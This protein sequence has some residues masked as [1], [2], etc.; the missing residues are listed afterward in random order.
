MSETV[1]SFIPTSSFDISHNEGCKAN[2]EFKNGKPINPPWLTVYD[3][4]W[5]NLKWIESNF[6]LSDTV[7]WRVVPQKDRP[8]LILYQ[9]NSNGLYLPVLEN[10][11]IF[12]T[13]RF[14]G[15]DKDMGEDKNPE[16]FDHKLSM[17]LTP[18]SNMALMKWQE[19]QR[20][21]M[22]AALAARADIWGPMYAERTSCGAEIVIERMLSKWGWK[23][24]NPK[25]KNDKDAVLKMEK[26]KMAPMVRGHNPETE[27]AG[28]FTV[29]MASKT[30][31]KL[32][33]NYVMKKGD[34]LELADKVFYNWD[35]FFDE[36]GNYYPN[37]NPTSLKRDDLVNGSKGFL[38]FAHCGFTFATS[39]E[40]YN[41]IKAFGGIVK[42]GVVRG[43][44]IQASSFADG[45]KKAGSLKPIEDMTPHQDEYANFD[46]HEPVHIGGGGF[47]TNVAKRDRSNETNGYEASKRLQTDP[48]LKGVMNGIYQFICNN[49]N[50]NGVDRKLIL[51]C[52]SEG[53]SE[54]YVN[55]CIEQL[56]ESSKIYCTIDMNHFQSVCE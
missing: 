47:T 23:V 11:S 50:K 30:I 35:D 41:T 24:P 33:E 44:G 12:Y 7:R 15:G 1:K 31:Q 52:F 13:I 5:L 36:N 27:W 46:E 55:S 8:Q 2:I 9:M 51:S 18:E 14:F 10:N 53:R 37:P 49:K 17:Q 42:K 54:E 43:S 22:L 48:E 25:D 3:D 32:P 6:R 39:I 38:R 40:W 26:E 29:G 28:G 45:L 20:A 4:D 34:T 16:G 19:I 21:Y 56:Q